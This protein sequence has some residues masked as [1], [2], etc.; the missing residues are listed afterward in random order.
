MPTKIKAANFKKL[1]KT[2]KAVI[3]PFIIAKLIFFCC[4]K[5]FLTIYQT[6]NT[7]I[8]FIFRDLFSLVK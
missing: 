7:M 1:L 5:Q 4:M 8:P 6:D 2:Y 3:Y